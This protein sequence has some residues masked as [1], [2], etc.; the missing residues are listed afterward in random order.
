MKYARKVLSTFFT[1]LANFFIAKIV[2]ESV[3]LPGDMRMMN[4]LISVVNTICM[5]DYMLQNSTSYFV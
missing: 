1:Q 4:Y 3:Y 2:H 5:V